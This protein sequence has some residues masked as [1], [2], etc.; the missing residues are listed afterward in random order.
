MEAYNMWK[1]VQNQD[2]IAFDVTAT[3]LMRCYEADGHPEEQW[4]F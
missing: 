2:P 1:M 4:E 3:V